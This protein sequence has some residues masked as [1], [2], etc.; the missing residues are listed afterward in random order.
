MDRKAALEQKKKRLRELKQRR[1]EHESSK[2]TDVSEE[3]IR[4]DEKPKAQGSRVSVAIQTDLVFETEHNIIE[5]HSTPQNDNVNKEVFR[6]EKGIQVDGPLEHTFSTTTVPNDIESSQ[7][8][9]SHDK[10]ETSILEEDEHAINLQVKDAF[11][12]LGHIL[13][14]TEHEIGYESSF[15]DRV[16]EELEKTKSSQTE[17]ENPLKELYRVSATQHRSVRFVEI[18]PHFNDLIAVCYGTSK[19]PK[20]DSMRQEKRYSHSSYTNSDGLVIIYKIK[21]S[22]MV[23]EFYLLANA[24][25]STISFSRR[26]PQKIIGGLNNGQ[27][28]IWNLVDTRHTQVAILPS[29]ISPVYSTINTV[30]SNNKEIKFVP[31]SSMICCIEQSDLKQDQF[32]TIC[33]EGIVNIW[34]MNLLACPRFNSLQIK[35]T[36]D[37]G[38]E[39]SKDSILHIVK[40]IHT[41]GIAQSVMSYK[42]DDLSNGF[43]EYKVLNNM[44]LGCLNGELVK[45]SNKTENFI[46]F[47]LENDNK[48]KSGSDLLALPTVLSLKS[49]K[50]NENFPFLVSSALDMTIKIWDLKNKTT[51]VSIPITYLAFDIVINP[52]KK[53]QFVTVGLSEDINNSQTVPVLE[54]WDLKSKVMSA[55][56]RMTLPAG[57]NT[58]PDAN[59]Y[60]VSALF[61]SEN[62][63]VVGLSNG[64]IIYYSIDQQLLS[65]GSD[66]AKH[67]E[68]HDGIDHYLINI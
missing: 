5:Q 60:A 11:K 6:P 42:S 40:G 23:P 9:I 57:E 51:L 29:L 37:K 61:R 50:L 33:S 16:R 20:R 43:T 3:D 68:I 19:L 46:D 27:I 55:I 54:F 17:L 53:A 63:L 31:H 49:I 2:S 32:V 15:K 48:E 12:K 13:I 58:S 64:E 30:K 65:V 38:T 52:F 45:L 59:L 7:S 47:I 34:S 26:D 39:F 44:I 56:Y 62:E 4:P 14:E 25:V 1:L 21:D 22:K 18:S 35:K 10:T 36:D 24:A 8:E 41:Y 67:N 28:V 66:K